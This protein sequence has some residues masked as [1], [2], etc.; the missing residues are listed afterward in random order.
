LPR[1]SPRAAAQVGRQGQRAARA[2]I[3]RVCGGD[4]RTAQ[5]S[6]HDRATATRCQMI[7][8]WR[9][10][11]TRRAVRSSCREQRG[12]GDEDERTALSRACTSAL[13]PRL[14]ARSR[15]ATASRLRGGGT[16]LWKMSTYVSRVCDATRLVSSR[17]S[18]P[19]G[20]A[21]SPGADV[22]VSESRPG[23]G[24]VFATVARSILRAERFRRSRVGRRAENPS[25]GDF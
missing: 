18:M 24:V 8:S 14:P 19:A 15:R 11:A 21:R 10:L 23:V 13:R 22:G 25:S 9:L 16:C 5:T 7:R 1:C 3:P 20:A 6:E 12:S 17:R 4:C 2:S